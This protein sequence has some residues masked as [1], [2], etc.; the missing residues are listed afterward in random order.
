MHSFHTL[1]VGSVSVRSANIT[2]K[3]GSEVGLV[4]VALA[5]V[6]EGTKLG[7]S[8]SSVGF[9]N[10]SSRRPLSLLRLMQVL[11]DIMISSMAN[12]SEV[13]MEGEDRVVYQK[14]LVALKLDRYSLLVA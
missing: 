5:D 14:I 7:S 11:F 9:V 13:Y 2:F 1:L 6:C 10:T 4:T 8:V 3:A 12:R